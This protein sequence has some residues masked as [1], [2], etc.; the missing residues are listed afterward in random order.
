M[1][2][3]IEL[4]SGPHHNLKPTK[5]GVQDLIET[6]DRVLKR[7]MRSCDDLRFIDIKSILQGIQEQ[8]PEVPRNR[9]I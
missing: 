1:K 3:T 7:N 6:I 8:I 4:V 9:F 2:I 5:D